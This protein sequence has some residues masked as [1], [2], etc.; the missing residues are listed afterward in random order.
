MDLITAFY[1]NLTKKIGSRFRNI[2]I[3]NF[4]YFFI[5][6][7][8]GR[9]FLCVFVLFLQLIPERKGETQLLLQRMQAGDFPPDQHLIIE[10][11]I[12]DVR[13]FQHFVERCLDV[14]LV[15]VALNGSTHS[16][17]FFET[18][19]GEETIE[20]DVNTGVTGNSG[21][22]GTV[23]VSGVATANNALAGGGAFGITYN[24]TIP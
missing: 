16:T 10:H 6:F 13:V 1:A 9:L 20:S 17:G 7:Q 12:Q 11:M 19:N 23:T 22:T 8:Q 4:L 21:N 18:A 2:P 5:S 24:I 14:F 15:A 3:F